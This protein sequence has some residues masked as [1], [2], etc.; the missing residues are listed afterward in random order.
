MGEVLEL[1]LYDTTIEC[2]TTVVVERERVA[3]CWW[4]SVAC[5]SPEREIYLSYW[6]SG[7]GMDW[8]S[9]LIIDMEAYLSRLFVGGKAGQV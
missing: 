7:I 1:D 2:D 3:T 8:K 9:N 5:G 6:R 4:F